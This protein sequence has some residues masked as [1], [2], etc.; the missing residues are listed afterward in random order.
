M[1]VLADICC[2]IYYVIATVQT[3]PMIARILRTKSSSDY[4]LVGILLSFIST[5][6]WTTYIYL[7]EH[8]L[9]VYLG[10]AWDALVALVYYVA[11]IRY[12]ENNPF[13]KKVESFDRRTET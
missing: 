12:H 6:A 13:R 2:I 9:L 5:T 1:T 4:S 11:V 3:I 10:T 7:S 8:T